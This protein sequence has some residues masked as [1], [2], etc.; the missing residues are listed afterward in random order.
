MSA[1]GQAVSG[2]AFRITALVSILQVRGL[3]VI[4]DCGTL[5]RL[6]HLGSIFA[7][8]LKQQKQKVTKKTLLVFSVR[9][10]TSSGLCGPFYSGA[11]PPLTLTSKG[12]YT[13]CFWA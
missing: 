6:S 5:V 11:S 1:T 13:L 8:A 4:R 12:W 9:P 7:S 3:P 2:S 10:P